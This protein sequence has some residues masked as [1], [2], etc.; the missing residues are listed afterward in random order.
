MFLQAFPLLGGFVPFNQVGTLLG[1]AWLGK[2]RGPGSVPPL[3]GKVQELG[4]TPVPSRDGDD[5]TE[6]GNRGSS[7]TSDASSG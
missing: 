6:P 5:L 2:G 7:P 3:P 1:P 4:T